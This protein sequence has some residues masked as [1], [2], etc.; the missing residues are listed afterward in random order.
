[1]CDALDSIPSGRKGARRRNEG[2]KE[3]MIISF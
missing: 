2:E 1:M 3:T